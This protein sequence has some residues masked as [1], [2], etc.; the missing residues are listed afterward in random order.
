[1]AMTEI[2]A[3]LPER[4]RSLAGI[5]T[6]ASHRRDVVEA[7][8]ELTTLRARLARCEEALT[9]IADEQ[10]VYKG[11]GDYDILPALTAEEAQMSARTALSEG[12]QR[13]GD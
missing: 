1:M 9:Q 2:D 11:H 7:A 13:E 3:K 12:A 10:K 6:N 8:D 5:F 4:L